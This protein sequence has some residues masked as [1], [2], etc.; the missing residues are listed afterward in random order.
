MRPYLCDSLLARHLVRS[1]VSLPFDWL[2]GNACCLGWREVSDD[3]R[4]P[5][6]DQME[7]CKPRSRLLPQRLLAD[8]QVY[9]QRWIVLFL[10]LQLRTSHRLQQLQLDT[11][12]F[13]C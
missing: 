1:R 2:A 11:S 12:P 4:Q 10:R 7:V 8:R 13:N 3:G 5:M 6:L 9:R